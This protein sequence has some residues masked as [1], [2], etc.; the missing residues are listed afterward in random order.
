MVTMDP[1]ATKA[2]PRSVMKSKWTRWLTAV[3][4]T[5]GATFGVA[6]CD[7]DP[8]DPDQIEEQLDETEEEIRENTP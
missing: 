5:A 7:R 8:D 2:Q 6:A 1:R 3:A 4:I